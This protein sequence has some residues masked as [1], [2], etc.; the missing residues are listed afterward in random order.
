M[1]FRICESVYI[2]INKSI[3]NVVSFTCSTVS[4]VNVCVAFV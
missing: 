4:H 3:A 1:K 2:Y